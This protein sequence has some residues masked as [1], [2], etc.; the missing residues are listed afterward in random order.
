MTDPSPDQAP[1]NSWGPRMLNGALWMIALRWAIRLTGLVS[2]VILARLLMPS[3]FGIVAMAMIVVSTLEIFNQTG[4]KL[5]L[6]RMENP[7]KDHFDTAWTVSFLIGLAI[8]VAILAAS[9]LAEL[10]FH[11]PKVEPVMQC[12]ALRA[13]M[14]G[15]ENIG[16]VNF[17]RDLKFNSFFAYNVYPK[18]ISFTVT[19]ALA[20][21]LRNYWALVAGILI[22]QFAL[23]VLSYI[24]H[25]HRPRFTLSKMRDIWS[26]SIWTFFRSIGYYLNGQIDQI[27]VGGFGGAA[28]M[29]RY[30]VA[31]D[32]A[33]SPGREIN[34]PMVAVLYPVMSRLQ[35]DMPALRDVYLKTLGWTAFI[36]A[37]TGV[38]VALVAPDMQQLVLGDKWAGIAP[39]MSWLAIGGAISGL[40]SGAYSL[41][42]ALNQPRIGARMIWVRLFILGAAIVPVAF[43]TK[44]LIDIAICRAVGEALFLPG[45]FH[46]VHRLANISFMHYLKTLYRPFL[47]SLLMAIVVL[48]TNMTL[49]ISGN[50][51]LAI[52]IGLGAAVFLAGTWLLWRA[53]GRPRTPEADVFDAIAKIARL[54][55]ALARN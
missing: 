18:L 21:M 52:D 34:E 30:A 37:A 31:T 46:A 13:I 12:L 54:S 5:V 49:P 19:V 43:W 11:E 6:I 39:L 7:T 38:G 3:D 15:L 1:P 23:I 2:T 47:A 17:R 28:L 48:G 53:A 41:F 51:R 27:V 50:Y 35:D 4:Q 9:P 44:S 16:T 32:V 40:S 8:A 33:Q 55:P 36:C 24:M 29:G 20:F 14:G 22:G 45:L 10:Y 26:F 25:P 42:D